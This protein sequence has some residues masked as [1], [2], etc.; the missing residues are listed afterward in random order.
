S[1]TKG[2]RYHV[3]IAW[4][5]T[6]TNADTVPDR[7]D[8]S[9]W[10]DGK[11]QSTPTTVTGLSYATWEAANAP[12]YL[13]AANSSSGNVQFFNGGIDAFR[14]MNAAPNLEFD[15]S[16]IPSLSNYDSEM[17]NTV[18]RYDFD[19]DAFES[20]WESDPDKKRVAIDSTSSFTPANA[21]YRSA[22]PT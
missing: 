12:M 5:W 19:T 4:K 9:F 15:L 8:A 20:G 1:W 11:L 21:F 16:S 6:D 3:A 13:G 22:D 17:T 10:I 18:Y 7:M 14:M 2:R